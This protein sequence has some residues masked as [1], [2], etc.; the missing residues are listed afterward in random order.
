MRDFCRSLSHK[1]NVLLL[2]PVEFIIEVKA[3][4]HTHK[5]TF[6]HVMHM[7]WNILALSSLIIII[8]IICSASLKY[9]HFLKTLEFM[10]RFDVRA[11]Q[12]Q[13]QR[14]IRT[15]DMHSYGVSGATLR[16]IVEMLYL[17]IDLSVSGQ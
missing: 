10:G 15:M 1:P 11:L 9:Q 16:S 8:I 3:F 5:C 4:I 6:A 17:E 7:Q 2:L 13:M 14:D 12:M